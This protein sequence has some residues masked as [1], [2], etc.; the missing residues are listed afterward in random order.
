MVKEKIIEN[1]A[2]RGKRS[3]GSPQ[4]FY[5]TAGTW[6]YSVART[7]KGVWE[8]GIVFLRPPQSPPWSLVDSRRERASHTPPPSFWRTLTYKRVPDPFPW[9]YFLPRHY[10]EEITFL[11]VVTTS[12]F[13]PYL[14]WPRIERR[15][16]RKRKE[17]KTL[18]QARVGATEFPSY[19]I[20]AV[21]NF[22]IPKN[23]SRDEVVKS[24]GDWKLYRDQLYEHDRFRGGDVNQTIERDSCTFAPYRFFPWLYHRRQHQLRI[25]E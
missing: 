14:S 1:L 19:C 18:P 7:S 11:P 24:E 21:P 23:H 15:R 12:S 22:R 9:P 20:A 17:K 13:H 5:E 4:G 25:T 8:N 6:W 2:S 16:K 3:R 10:P